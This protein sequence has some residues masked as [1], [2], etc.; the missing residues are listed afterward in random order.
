MPNKIILYGGLHHGELRECGADILRLPNSEYVRTKMFQ[1]IYEGDGNEFI[2]DKKPE[3]VRRT[4]YVWDA[5]FQE[6]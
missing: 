3:L 1:E 4:V 5:I 6:L 2:Q